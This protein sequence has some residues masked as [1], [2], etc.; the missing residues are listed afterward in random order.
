MSDQLGGKSG[1]GTLRISHLENRDLSQ[2]AWRKTE[3]CLARSGPRKFQGCRHHVENLLRVMGKVM[4]VEYVSPKIDLE[5]ILGP[6]YCGGMRYSA[7]RGNMG[8]S[9]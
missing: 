3:R 8:S 2:A 1:L 6:L 7:V 4:T 5:Y 9:H